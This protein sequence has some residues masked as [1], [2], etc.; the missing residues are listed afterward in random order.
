[1]ESVDLEGNTPWAVEHLSAARYLVHPDLTFVTT[2]V[3]V[4]PLRTFRHERL[5]PFRRPLADLRRAKGK[6]RAISD[7]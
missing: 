3:S 5:Q 7:F 2:S 4:I 1:M 6:Q